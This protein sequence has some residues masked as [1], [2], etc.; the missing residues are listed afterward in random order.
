MKKR[1]LVCLCL[2][3]GLGSTIASQAQTLA[4]SAMADTYLKSGSSNQNQGSE[5]LL[6]IRSSG[7]NRSLVRFDPAAIDAV[8]PGLAFQSWN[9]SGRATFQIWEP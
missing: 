8:R 6:R 2:G 9:R 4:L 7:K 1:S 3:L 5:A